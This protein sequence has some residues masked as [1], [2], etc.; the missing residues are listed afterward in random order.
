MS[1]ETD[2]ISML[3]HHAME[4]YMRKDVT[5]TSP[6]DSVESCKLQTL[7]LC[8]QAKS[9]L[10]TGQEAACSPKPVWMRQ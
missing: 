6:R 1:K 9:L 3:M 2:T 10:P 8:P 5:H 7:L 4:S